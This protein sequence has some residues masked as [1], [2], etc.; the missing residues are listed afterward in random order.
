MRGASSVRWAFNT[1]EWNPTVQEWLLATM[2][3]PLE[4]KERIQ[5]FVFKADA[6][7][8]IAGC[9]MIRKFVHLATSVPYE[10][11][12]ITRDKGGRPYF[13]SS[14]YHLE[15]NIS[16]QGN[17]TVL[18]G[19]VRSDVNVGVDIVKFE[20]KSGFELSELF[21]LT[22]QSF[23]NEEWS[24]ILAPDCDSKRSAMFFRHWCLKESY[25]KATGVGICTDLQSIS[26]KVNTDTLSFQE[27][28]IDTI[29]EV[30]KEIKSDWR[31]QEWLLD[32]EHC[33]VVALSSDD[34]IK[35]PPVAFTLLSWSD[36]VREAKPLLPP[37]MI[38]CE[39]F[40][41]KKEHVS[42]LD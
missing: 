22:K 18:A 9:L 34:P 38:N 30:N 41:T 28:C 1:K 12:I 23:T 17:F 27:P 15:F 2:C 13:K 14:K 6:K 26:F 29:V 16:H 5:K 36:L 11:I 39:L 31:F 24:T 7:A 37:D 42:C 33:V 21:R 10:Q 3:V 32:A 25:V 35:L 4:E 20:S 8:S 19:E 40:M